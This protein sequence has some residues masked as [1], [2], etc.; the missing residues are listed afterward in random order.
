MMDEEVY[1]AVR[2]IPEGRVAT[3]KVISQMIGRPK[4]YRA[5]GTILAKNKYPYRDRESF[6]GTLLVN[7]HRVIK[8]N[9]EIGGFFGKSNL[10][11]DKE[12]LLKK[13]GIEIKNGKI[14][15]K[16]YLWTPD[17]TI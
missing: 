11:G 9:G 15:L 16:R 5:V 1:A 7:C 13:E 8:S 4:A 14:D 10:V 3:Y 17:G 2:K 6:D 12:E